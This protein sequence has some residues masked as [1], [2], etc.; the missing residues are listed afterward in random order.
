MSSSR[1]EAEKKKAQ[2]KRSQRLS[3]AFSA[4]VVAHSRAARPRTAPPQGTLSTKA[5]RKQI[6]AHCQS[7]IDKFRRAQLVQTKKLRKLREQERFVRLEIS[8]MKEK[9]VCKSLVSD[10]VDT[11]L[12]VYKH[13]LESEKKLLKRLEQQLDALHKRENMLDV[14]HDA[15]RA[16][17][18]EYR[19]VHLKTQHVARG[20]E[21]RLKAAM[22][23]M[24]RLMDRAE[25]LYRVRQERVRVKEEKGEVF[26]AEGVVIREEMDD[27]QRVLDE[28]RQSTFHFVFHFCIAILISV[29]KRH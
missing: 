19:Y 18:D 27:L 25:E 5:K 12:D 29:L 8:R 24:A 9:R 14:E 7:K 20:L 23:K 15:L 4:K 3:A 2:F 22:R 16:E 13:K 11:G 17:C 21:A 26:D 28:V 6:M 1:R 10:K